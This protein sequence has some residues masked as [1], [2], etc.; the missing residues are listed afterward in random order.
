MT[1]I[2]KLSKEML[3]NEHLPKW[4]RSL[5]EKLISSLKMCVF[6]FRI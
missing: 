5:Y 3:L 6:A 2:L 1:A 4:G